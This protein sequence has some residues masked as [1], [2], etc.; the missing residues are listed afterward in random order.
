MNS[1][2]A[3]TASRAA[4]LNP[5]GIASISPGLRGTSYPGYGSAKINN[6]ERVA[7]HFVN[8]NSVRKDGCNPVG[9]EDFC[10]ACPRVARPSQPWAE[11]S[12]PFG[13]AGG[14]AQVAGNANRAPALWFTPE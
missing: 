9:V 7:S 4:C 5:K 2:A 8:L 11:G 13:I 10:V 12:N 6:P 3:H 1:F 14:A